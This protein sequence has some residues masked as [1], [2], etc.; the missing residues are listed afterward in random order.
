MVDVGLTVIEAPVAPVDHV[1]VPEQA[2]A[3][4]VTASPIQIEVRLAEMVGALG[5][6]PG[7]TVIW[8]D[9]PEVQLATL[10]TAE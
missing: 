9:E 8:L 5:R 2:D 10:Q 3:V 1:T 7:V 6:V 4:K